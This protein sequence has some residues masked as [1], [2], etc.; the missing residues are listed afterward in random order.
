MVKSPGGNV[1]YLRRHHNKIFGT[2]IHSKIQGN[3]CGVVVVSVL[4]KL[5]VV[6]EMQREVVLKREGLPNY[7]V[8]PVLLIRLNPGCP[9][10]DRRIKK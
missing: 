1:S 3:I 9:A 8:A 7:G 10:H 4:Y 2:F 6:I 5:G